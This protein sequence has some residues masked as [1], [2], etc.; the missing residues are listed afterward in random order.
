MSS[1]ENYI[2]T[3][4]DRAVRD[5]GIVTKAARAP[6][7]SLSSPLQSARLLRE[8]FRAS[9]V[10]GLHFVSGEFFRWNGSYFEVVS[11]DAMR[12]TGYKWLSGCVDAQAATPIA[13]NRRCVT[14]LLDALKGESHATQS[15][16]L[17]GWTTRTTPIRATSLL[18]RTGC[19]TPTRNLLP[20]DPRLFATSA[21]PINFDP[22][23]Q[24]PENWLSFLNS[25]WPDDPE[26]IAAMREWFGLC[27]LTGDTSLQK[28][29]LMV[30]P[31]RSGK[32][33]IFRALRALT[34]DANV[35]CADLRFA[36]ISLCVGFIHQQASGTGRFL[37]PRMRRPHRRGDGRGEH[38][39]HH[40]RRCHFRLRANTSRLDRGNCLLAS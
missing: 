4:E 20:P 12:A 25:V 2:S 6:K 34:G 11:D 27:A 13:P 15:H 7:I 3:I 32:G 19:Y 16:R 35:Y 39:A 31:R 38:P 33:T 24:Q 28:A 30:G 1:V 36:G 21:L 8:S 10:H 17:N 14:D 26:S 23:S 40:R 29:L 9:G 22:H 5:L 37:T 18:L